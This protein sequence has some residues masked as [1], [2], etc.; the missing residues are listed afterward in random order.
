MRLLFMFLSAEN[1][2]FENVVFDSKS[3]IFIQNN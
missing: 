2:Q 3:V 1:C